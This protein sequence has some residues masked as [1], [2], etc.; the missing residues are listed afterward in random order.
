MNKPE[1][2][3][4][5]AELGEMTKK[6]AE[7]AVNALLKTIEIT[8]AKGEDI[9]IVGHGTYSVKHR[10]S[11]KGRNP[12]T[13]E[14]IQIDAH[15]VPVFKPGKDLEVAVVDVVVLQKVKW[16]FRGKKKEVVE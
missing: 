6:D 16:E 1:M 10:K 9:K 15:N 14:E 8:L 11:R 2:I 13:G 12:Q 5:V 4:S 7:K 3:A